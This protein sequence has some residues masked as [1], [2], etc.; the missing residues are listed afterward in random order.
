MGGSVL[1][2]IALVC[3]ARTI[4]RRW[5]RQDAIEQLGMGRGHAFVVG[6]EPLTSIA[7]DEREY[8]ECTVID[9]GTPE[10]DDRIVRWLEGAPNHLRVLKS[11]LHD[12]ERVQ[13]AT[14]ETEQENQRLREAA[15]RLETQLENSE[16]DRDRLQQEI[17]QLKVTMEQYRQEITL[18][19]AALV[20]GLDHLQGVS[21]QA[22]GSSRRGGP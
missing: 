20:D 14:D 15:R 16:R 2:A 21:E 10:R 12:Y 5:T 7:E 9:V 19:V 11:I 6:S 13:K 1:G 17:S 8:R 22:P 3:L 4:Q 18:T